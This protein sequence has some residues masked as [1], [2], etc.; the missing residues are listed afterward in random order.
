MNGIVRNSNTGL[1]IT[2][3]LFATLLACRH[4]HLPSLST[5]GRDYD[6][7]ILV[8]DTAGL[9]AGPIDSNL[10]NPWGMAIS[11]KGS[12]W[13]S[14][15][16]SGRTVIY[17]ATGKQTLAPVAIPLRSIQF[18]ASPTGAVYN[19]TSGFIANGAPEKFMYATEDGIIAGWNGG[20][21]TYTVVDRS[22]QKA[23]YKGIA[24]ANDSTGNFLYATDFFNNRIDVFDASFHYIS[25]RQ[26]VDATIP[27]G[28]APFNIRN[29][30][31][32]LFVTYAKQIPP[33]N[34][35]DQRGAGNGYIDIFNPNGTFIKRF[36]TQGALNSPWGIARASADFGQGEG[37]I[38]VANFG[39]GT[40]LIFDS[41]GDYKGPLE[42]NGV[43]LF[44]DGVWD[45]AFAPSSATQLYFTAGPS[46]E[47]YGLF[48]YMRLK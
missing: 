23:V 41:S 27:A 14:C 48:G 44:I 28:F 47:T 36:A 24:I 10:A 3:L 37:A 25:S 21:S 19:T 45:I 40:T 7:T 29:I 20:D 33:D 46:Q 42:N 17:D 13:I 9:A 6:A 32:K 2:V 8:A 11:T 39:D 26:L 35:D 31:G 22:A 16:H 43:P 30:G 15:N 12:I 4:E 5:G 18:G 38:L 34:H 1:Y